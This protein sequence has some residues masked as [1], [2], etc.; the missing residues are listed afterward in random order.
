MMTQCMTKPLVMQCAVLMHNEYGSH[1]RTHAMCSPGS[2]R[3][4]MHNESG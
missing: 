1:I 4:M 2:T 3:C